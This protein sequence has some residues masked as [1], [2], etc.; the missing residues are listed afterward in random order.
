M[1]R[2]SCK[3]HL[4]KWHI[5][6]AYDLKLHFQHSSSFLLLIAVKINTT[7][8]SFSDG[9][10]LPNH[11]RQSVLANGSMVIENAHKL[12]DEGFY[13]CTARNQHDDSH[14]GTVQIEVLSK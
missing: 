9:Y 11:G 5:N 14:S 10:E 2:N 12:H 7:I 3:H 1:L 8:Y 13:T 6:N 4:E